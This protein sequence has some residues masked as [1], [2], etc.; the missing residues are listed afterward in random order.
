[1]KSEK[2]GAGLFMLLLLWGIAACGRLRVIA[3]DY[4]DTIGKYYT[5]RGFRMYT[6][7]YGKGKPL[8][9]I[10]GN[11]GNMSAFAN[12][13]PYFSRKYKV[14]LADSRAHGRSADPS[15]SLSFEMMAD[16]Y[17]ALLSA[18]H[19]SS[20]YV[21]GW[22]DG[23]IIALELAM[24]HPE[25]V[26]RL[27]STGANL[28]ADSVGLRPD[29]WRDG[30][31]DYQAWQK[32][33]PLTGE[34]EKNDYKVFM[35]DFEQPH[36]ALQELQKIRCPALIIGGDNDLIPVA[37]TRQIAAGIRKASLW[38]VPHSGHATLV[39]HSRAFNKRVDAF[40]RKPFRHQRR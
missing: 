31:R 10:H 19:I 23:G 4:N 15:D 24:R 12:N 34:K 38:I 27:A 2:I 26:I 30:V 20:A 14:I 9:M 29:V 18:M 11:G 7:T 32:R 35:L 33:M 8:L 3:Y 16:D 22:S 37:H 40:F 39:D 1:M 28:W 13:V 36:I 25:K 17:S 6:E 5:V 21:L